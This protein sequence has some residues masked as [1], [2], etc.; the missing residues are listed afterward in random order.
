MDNELEKQESPAKSP[1][2]RARTTSRQTE[3]PQAEPVVTEVPQEE[4]S[5]QEAPVTEEPSLQEAPVAE[6]PAPAPAV[7][8]APTPAPAPAPVAEVIE[9]PRVKKKKTIL[10]SIPT[11]VSNRGMRNRI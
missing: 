8:P 1:R 11:G 6:E 9:A 5:L 7:E 3:V 4:P 10:P 2:R